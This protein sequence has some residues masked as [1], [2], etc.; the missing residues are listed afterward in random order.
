MTDATASSGLA[1]P[2]FDI[3][4]SLGS[5]LHYGSLALTALDGRRYDFV[6]RE[7]GPAAAL[8][9][10]RRGFGRRL[11]TGGD[12]GF[13]EAYIDGF[14]D[15]PD[16]PALIELAARNEHAAWGGLLNGRPLARLGARLRHLARPNTRSG[17]RRN[18]AEHYDLGNDFYRLWLDPTMTYSAALFADPKEELAAAQYRKYARLAELAGIEAGDHVLEIGCGWG[19]F[20]EFVASELACRVTGVT[21][22][23]AQHNW[24]RRRIAEAGLASRVDIVKCD[25]RDLDGCYDRI[26]SIE[27]LEAV[28]ERY[29]PVY[30]NRLKSLLKPGGGAALQVIT[31]D[32]AHWAQYRRNVDFI[33]L[34]VFPGGMLPT[35]G[36]LAAQAGAAG[37]S[38]RESRA[39]GADYARTLERWQAAFDAN[40]DAIAGLGFD[41]RFR[42]L[43][44]YYLAYCIAGFRVGRIDVQ[45]IG[46]TRS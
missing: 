45:Q 20:A 15:S 42:R 10:A 40:W 43:W 25:Y 13:A 34:Y 8:S 22:S 28:G 37:L 44:T 41:A 29:W 2:R 16:L 21:I 14:C 24:A 7:P 23:D 36:K 18:I 5:R 46:L 27:M 33:Q 32:E 1:L 39:Y 35:V 26:V 11:V 6:G 31:M 9:V 38:W 3:V 19:G 17:S 30:F 4:A 12:L